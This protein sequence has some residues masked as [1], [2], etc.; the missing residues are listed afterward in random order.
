ML[1]LI[2]V[3]WIATC[4]APCVGQAAVP[5]PWRVPDVPA[6]RPLEAGFSG[7]DANILDG[8]SCDEDD[9]CTFRNACGASAAGST[10]A[11]DDNL[12]VLFDG[13][14]WSGGCADA[15]CDLPHSGVGD[16]ASAS[17]FVP[18]AT[19]A[20]PKQ[21][22]AFKTGCFGLG[23]YSDD[24]PTMSFGS[25]VTISLDAL[26]PPPAREEGGQPQSAS[27]SADGHAPRPA[28][29]APLG[30]HPH[31][32]AMG[33]Q[34]AHRGPR[35]RRRAAVATYTIPADADA[36]DGAWKKAGLWAIDSVNPNSWVGAMGYLERTAADA[37][38]VQETRKIGA[39][40]TAAERQ[41]AHVGWNTSVRAAERTEADGITAG[42]AV[43]VRKHIGLAH[44]GCGT[45]DLGI[46][47]SSR[48]HARW[49]GGFVR[50]GIHL[51]TCWPHHSE[52]PTPRNQDILQEV[53]QVINSVDGL[54][55]VGADWN[56]SPT[57]LEATGWL[58]LVDGVAIAPDS[59]TCGTSCIDYF[60]VPRRLLHAVAG[61]STIGDAGL[62]PHKPVRLYLK[63]TARMLKVRRLRAPRQFPTTGAPL[64]CLPRAACQPI[65]RRANASPMRLD[66]VDGP[67]ESNSDTLR[68]TAND[69]DSGGDVVSYARWL[70]TV[71]CEL[72]DIHGIHDDHAREAFRGRASGPSFIWETALGRRC[73]ETLHSNE[74]SRG[75][76]LVA[77]AAHDLSV[78][79]DLTA[80]GRPVPE[81]VSRAADKAFRRLAS[82][83][84][85]AH[86]GCPVAAAA[87]AVA[88]CTSLELRRRLEASAR[89]NA[90]GHERALA[91]ERRKL[92]STWIRGGPCSG[93]GRQHRFSRVP[94]GWTPTKVGAA[95]RPALSRLDIVDGSGEAWPHDGGELEGG[96]GDQR[97]IRILTQSQLGTRPLD[98]QSVVEDQALQWAEHWAA[99]KGMPRPQWPR[100]IG[101]R[102]LNRPSVGQL[103]AALGSFPDKTALGTDAMHPRVLRR[104]SDERLDQLISILMHAEALG[105]WPECIGTVSIVLLPKADGGW[106][107][108]GLFPALIRV[109]MRLRRGLAQD[110]EA[111]HARGVLYA[112]KA[113][114]AQ[115][116]AWQQA[117]RAEM[118]AD[119][120]A[121]FAQLLLDVH[122]CFEHVPHHVLAEEAAALDYPLPLLRLALAAYRLPRTLAVGGVHS[123]LVHAERG[124]AAGSGLATTELRVLLLRLLDRVKRRCPTVRLSAY[125]DDLTADAAGTERSASEAVVAAGR[126]LCQGI[127]DL[128]L[129]LSAGKC[130]VL[131]TST[132]A[133]KTV[134]DGLARWTVK[135]ATHAK[136]LGVGVA[137][138]A[139]RTTKVQ[140]TRW[141]ALGA[142]LHR[143]AALLRENLSVARLFRT[144][145]T[146]A[147][148]YGDDVTGV[149]PKVLESRRR[150]V[151]AAVARGSA[152]RS[153][154]M[155]LALADDGSRQQLDPAFA[156]HLL[157]LGRW[158]EA[159]YSGW[160]D[161][162]ALDATIK[163][164]RIRLMR[165][166]RPWAAVKGPAAA[167]LASAARLGWDVTDAAH[168]RTDLG[169][170]L[171]L[172]R[173][174]PCIIKQ[175]VHEAV[176]RWRWKRICEV[177]GCP[178]GDDVDGGRECLDV[179]RRL[180]RPKAR[181]SSWTTC[182]QAALRSALVNGQW[183]QQRLCS[184][185][186]ADDGFCR[187]CQ[188]YGLPRAGCDAACINPEAPLGTLYHRLA[189]C[190]VVAQVHD[191]D[192]PTAADER[193]LVAAIITE[194]AG[195]VMDAEATNAVERDAEVVGQLVS[196]ASRARNGA[197]ASSTD[198]P[199]HDGGVRGCKRQQ[200]PWRARW[201]TQALQGVSRAQLTEAWAAAR[202]SAATMAS[203]ARAILPAMH[204]IRPQACDTDNLEEGTFEWT[205]RPPDDDDLPPL[206]FYTDGSAFDGTS[207]RLRRC[208]W[209]LV[210]VDASG[211]VVASASGS[212]PPW[213][214]T[215]AAA[216]AWA[217]LQAAR[218]AAPGTVFK[219]DCLAVLMAIRAGRE[220]A[221]A[222]D[223]PLA[224]TM[225]LIFNYFDDPSTPADVIWMPGHTTAA[226]V[227]RACLSDGS[228]L[229]Q[230]DYMAN[231]KADALAKAAAAARRVPPLA[232]AGSVARDLLCQRFARHIGRMTYV[233][234][235][236]GGP[237][238]RDSDPVPARARLVAERLVHAERPPRLGG[239]L[240][241]PQPDGR[242]G[243]HTCWKKAASRANLAKG[244]CTG[245]VFLRWAKRD[246]RLTATGC[247]DSTTH[248]LQMTGELV[249]CATCGAYSS[250]RAVGIMADCR[251]RPP[252]EG[253]WGR[254]TALSRLRRGL[255]PKTAAPLEAATWKRPPDLLQEASAMTQRGLREQLRNELGLPV[256]RENGHARTHDRARTPPP[257]WCPAPVRHGAH[258][259]GPQ[260]SPRQRVWRRRRHPDAA[261]PA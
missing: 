27:A 247:G 150:T 243:C 108:I 133:G 89:E 235:H 96:E 58:Q 202:A 126:L 93:L 82:L 78:R 85:R 233:A 198:A 91:S 41:A 30:V 221:T 36:A 120:G 90:A 50:G 213:V 206:T 196:D 113:R 116:A 179:F 234:N 151:A 251:G 249:W 48:V 134:V 115:V 200:R 152:G 37:A 67:T 119:A 84:G 245:D 186:L 239:H 240:P 156:A 141:A 131:S 230:V 45:A 64:G 137:A 42:L 194:A 29:T 244:R 107:P 1:L 39:Q 142:R 154:D 31:D 100:D 6:P 170:V 208:G 174:P 14:D 2:G 17:D 153:V 12:A 117:Q 94:S 172:R 75:W 250:Q 121:T 159:V 105:E 22:M 222:P 60:V 130:Q 83:V 210:A 149:A 182:H 7:G 74:M 253:H 15:Q 61:V 144:G 72:A 86:A 8:W 195:G 232:R 192:D 166:R 193:K 246:G 132:A 185:G 187:L 43:A 63:A 97:W 231:A 225:A 148:T 21:G 199:G 40:V 177:S 140:K 73:T 143:L 54:W 204:Q 111:Q 189:E 51:I 65:P 139:R 79:G 106:R 163:R 158:A 47:T 52:G 248:N 226:D 76:R 218:M 138:G 46:A 56:L 11:G 55:V 214:D 162:R 183:P 109:W 118:A 4:A 77:Q 201:V 238:Y 101:Q 57:A 70:E 180:L 66:S 205:V 87:A 181:S 53:A 257:M 146:A 32:G 229:S 188:A 110:W 88:Q 18:A 190:P 228:R 197:A 215:V 28:S 169:R 161:A 3:A 241:V 136:A 209:A 10:A 26:V 124:V 255:H 112:G 38:L 258:R 184:A 44:P 165:A 5:G 219:T 9:D 191:H 157:P 95:P 223:R 34:R 147:Y 212:T 207:K 160:A 176:E 24:P 125:V 203:W 167:T 16:A 68:P 145:L 102:P 92:W 35:S 259:L 260:A 13:D 123:S 62:H 59:A 261:G 171:D 129:T 216:E 128:G 211:R 103:R 127:T 104:L 175:E 71:E 236:A 254:H 114:G 20:G 49:M 224:R 256:V 168:F 98:L 173:D 135:L 23:Y 252:R 80:K 122:K 69:G 227:G 164:E 155:V 220:K 99:R 217:V 178:G 19:F 25:P 237:P 81:T 33:A 242:W